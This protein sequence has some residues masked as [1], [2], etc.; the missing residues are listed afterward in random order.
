M[1]PSVDFKILLMKDMGVTL[2]IVHT[3]TL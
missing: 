2:F 1:F 3:A